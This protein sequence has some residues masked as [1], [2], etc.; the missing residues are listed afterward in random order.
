MAATM[1]VALIQA[2]PQCGSVQG[3]QALHAASIQFA[4][5]LSVHKTGPKSA[6]RA[7]FGRAVPKKELFAISPPEGG[8]RSYAIIQKGFTKM[9]LSNG[10]TPL[11]YILW[12]YFPSPSPTSNPATRRRPCSSSHPPPRHPLLVPRCAHPRSSFVT[13]T[14]RHDDIPPP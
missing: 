5:M 14:T 12:P 6:I 3:L 11:Q 13:T 1:G 7:L 2:E 10:A 4:L 9:P 8:F